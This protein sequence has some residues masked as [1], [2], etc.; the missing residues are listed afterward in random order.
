M[1]GVQ[2]GGRGGAP[3]AVAPPERMVTQRERAKENRSCSPA[4]LPTTPEGALSQPVMGSW[5]KGAQVVRGRC[6]VL[7]SAW[8]AP[9][10]PSHLTPKLLNPNPAWMLP[11]ESHRPR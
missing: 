4:L 1:M 5:D 10:N 11:H 7:V 2:V 8:A 6:L 3:L 9:L